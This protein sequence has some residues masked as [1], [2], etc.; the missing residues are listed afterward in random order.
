MKNPDI[1]DEGEDGFCCLPGME[2]I[3]G[4]VEHESAGSIRFSPGWRDAYP[5][6]LPKKCVTLMKSPSCGLTWA[7]M[8]PLSI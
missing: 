5:L 3:L 8:P 6:S 4:Y 1:K 2:A 7:I